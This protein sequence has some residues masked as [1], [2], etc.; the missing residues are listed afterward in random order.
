MSG[1]AGTAPS[2][3]Q[4]GDRPERLRHAPALDHQAGQASGPL[5]IALGARRQLAGHELLGR[6]AAERADD[7]AAQLGL[8]HAVPIVLDALQ[9]HPEGLS[10]RDDKDLPHH[11]GAGEQDA[12]QG[13]AGRAGAARALVSP[14]ARPG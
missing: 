11:L 1:V 8:A 12:E 9:G 7:L 6:A 2:G 5:E 10:V 3:R 4:H 13:V 14:S